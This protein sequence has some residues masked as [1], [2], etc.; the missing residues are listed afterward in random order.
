P[1]SAPRAAPAKSASAAPP[2][3]QRT[4]RRSEPLGPFAERP[5]TA[6]L[7]YFHHFGIKIDQG[8]SRSTA[9]E[10]DERRPEER[11]QGRS[12]APQ[13]SVYNQR[14]ESPCSSASAHAPSVS[15]LLSCPRPIPRWRSHGG[16]CSCCAAH[17]RRC[18]RSPWAC[19]WARWN[20][21]SRSLP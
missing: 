8:V 7:S 6:V 12:P 3:E 16:A 18:L 13:R 1:S 10:P 2:Q 15:F 19:S 21:A 4:Y 14:K 20:A 5:S 9:E 11:R 17:S